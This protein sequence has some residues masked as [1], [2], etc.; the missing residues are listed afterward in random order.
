MPRGEIIK[1]TPI[2]NEDNFNGI[3]SSKMVVIKNT[4][5]LKPGFIAVPKIH[6]VALGGVFTLLSIILIAACVI[7]LNTRGPAGYHEN[8]QGRSCFP[9]L[10]LKCKD[11][12]CQCETN[13]YF[14][15]KCFSKKS[16]GSF[17]ANSNQ[18]IDSLIC[19]SGKCQ[20]ESG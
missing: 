9:N 4:K 20:C 10:G 3:I 19:F 15:K 13:Q 12:L 1:S 14:N 18:C 6:L 7:L 5:S 11:N 8:C 2:Y 16:F 17:C